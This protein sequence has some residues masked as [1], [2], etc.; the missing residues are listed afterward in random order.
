MSKKDFVQV[1]RITGDSSKAVI[2]IG[3]FNKAARTMGPNAQR[4][5]RQ[6][7]R[8][9][10]K[11]RHNAKRSGT[12]FMIMSK[13]AADAGAQIR[14]A[15]HFTLGIAG[16]H[17]LSE[18]LQGVYEAATRLQGLESAY[19]SVFGGFDEGGAQ[20]QFVKD[21]AYDLGIGLQTLAKDYQMLHA[22]AKGSNLEGAE[23]DRIFLAV[24]KAGRTLNLSAEDVSGTFR[25]L[26]QMMSKGKV[27]AEELRGQLGERLPGAF[28]LAAESMGVSTQ[29]LDKMLKRG[30]VLADDLLP[31]LAVTLENTYGKGAAEASKNAAASME[32]LRTAIFDVSAA[33]GQEYFLDPLGDSAE[34]LQDQL[35]D[36]ADTIRSG[37]IADAASELADYWAGGFADLV[38][39]AGVS[40]GGI[41][42][43]FGE[44]RKFLVQHFG[45]E[46]A[47]AIGDGLLHLPQNLRWAFAWI[48]TNAK[49]T[50]VNVGEDFDKLR[51]DFDYYTDLMGTAWDI[52]WKNIEVGALEGVE[53]VKDLYADGI[54][55]IYAPLADSADFLGMEDTAR[56]LRGAMDDLRTG[57]IGTSTEV[58]KLQNEL[59]AL[60]RR[61]DTGLEGVRDKELERIKR[62]A[63]AERKKHTDGFNAIHDDVIA[64]REAHKEAM[65]QIGA[66][67]DAFKQAI[68][69]ESALRRAALLGGTTRLDA[70]GDVSVALPASKPRS[71]GR[72]SLQSDRAGSGV[73]RKADSERLRALREHE[74]TVDQLEDSMLD[75]MALDDPFGAERLRAT[76]EYERTIAK[77]VE[78]EQNYAEA[79]RMALT[80]L[81]SEL[82]MT[83]P[84]TRAWREYAR[85]TQFGA[86]KMADALKG[87]FTTAE[88]ALAEFIKTGKFEVGDL[89]DY[90]EAQMAQ[91][92][93]KQIVNGIGNALGLGGGTGAAAGAQAG[94]A[95][96]GLGSFFGTALGGLLGGLFHEGGVPAAGEASGYRSVP[97]EVFRSAPRFHTGIGPRE[98]AAIIR[99]DEG[100]FTPGQMAAMASLDTVKQAAGETMTNNV[101]ITVNAPS[102]N[103]HEIA[104]TVGRE[105]ETT[106][107]GLGGRRATAGYSQGQI[108]SLAARMSTEGRRNW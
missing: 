51:A 103:A 96:G 41:V 85:E 15:F 56:V 69:Q 53:A 77:L 80:L 84:L 61:Y 38:E 18:G 2:E 62:V 98:Q 94:S 52:L 68:D 14:R 95:G 1:I 50:G 60:N 24:A 17:A 71:T 30:Q 66:Q 70:N 44:S 105:V 76:Q 75:L 20:L 79:K 64:K 46:L 35:R 3:K 82:A 47:K 104:R 78:S 67:S 27:Q 59:D 86:D 108:A 58:A 83:D 63:D 72:V 29:E 48:E 55:A 26:Q 31:R 87:A 34:F 37:E 25:A 42:H 74:R 4:S 49:N 23:T 90:I 101:S 88:D 45:P 12:E 16:V 36:L 102:G 65:A 19:A 8:A 11:L 5:T 81:D 57:V 33:A 54:S 10:D 13:A 28:R 93:A 89:L 107:N 6:A 7:G 21:M 99:K 22:A 39:H 100:V 91:M 92:A 97:A 40:A 106:L 43:A 9:F 32:R 73:Q